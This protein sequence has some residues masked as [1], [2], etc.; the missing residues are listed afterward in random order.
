MSLSSAVAHARNKRI[1]L[2]GIFNAPRDGGYNACGRRVV[3]LKVISGRSF[4]A[5]AFGHKKHTH[6]IS[7][8]LM[9]GELLVDFRDELFRR[10]NGLCH[11]GLL[12]G[13]KDTIAPRPAHRQPE[14]AAKQIALRKKLSMTADSDHSTTP[15]KKSPDEAGLTPRGNA[16]PENNHMM[17]QPTGG[18]CRISLKDGNDGD[19][20]TFS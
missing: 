11:G 10:D 6:A 2:K 8:G 20:N 15:T 5:G 4:A 7:I 17:I 3:R 1:D 19:Q 18:H 14:L 12:V 9:A 16:A 13:G